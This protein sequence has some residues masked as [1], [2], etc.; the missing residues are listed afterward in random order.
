MLR[1]FRGRVVNKAA[2]C[3]AKLLVWSCKTRLPKN[4]WPVFALG[5]NRE[6]FAC[7]LVSCRKLSVSCCGVSLIFSFD[8]ES[9]A[10]T[11]CL[12]KNFV[13]RSLKLLGVLQPT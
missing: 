3:E 1:I 2:K 9:G 11:R 13:Q 8:C 4:A 5:L 7:H 12:R 10:Q 6:P